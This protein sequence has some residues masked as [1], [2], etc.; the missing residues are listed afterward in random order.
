MSAAEKLNSLR[1]RKRVLLLTSEVHRQLAAAECAVAQERLAWVERAA[2]V[3][4]QVLPLASL[5]LPLWRLWTTRREQGA[6]S[7]P[8]RIA[9][10]L[11][12]AERLAGLVQLWRR[13]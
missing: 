12:L 7:W 11:P 9:S 13:L 1:E 2:S 4:R 3:A 8:G 5:A 10:A 6:G